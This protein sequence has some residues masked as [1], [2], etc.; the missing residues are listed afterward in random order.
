[1]RLAVLVFLSTKSEKQEKFAEFGEYLSENIISAL[2][3]ETK[4][5]KLFERKR[6]DLILGENSLS[7]SGLI[8]ADQARKIGELVPVDAVLSGT[9]TKLENYIDVNSR[10]I[11]A[12]TGEIMLTYSA[13]VTLTNDLKSLFTDRPVKLTEEDVCKANEN[14]INFLLNDISTPEKVRE[15]VKEAVK[16]PFEGNC[17]A[18]HYKIMNRFSRYEID[19]PEYQ[20]FLMKTIDAIPHPSKDYRAIETLRFIARKSKD[21]KKWELCLRI[22]KK[23]E[24]HSITGALRPFLD[25]PHKTE[26][27]NIIYKRIDQY[28]VLLKNNE[29]GLPKPVTFNKGFHQMLYALDNHYATDNTVSFYCYLKYKNDLTYDKDMNNTVDNYLTRIYINEKNADLKLKML[30]SLCDFY[31][32]RQPDNELADDLFKF[33]S[34]FER[35]SYMKKNPEEEAKVPLAHLKIFIEKCKPMF[36]KTIGFTKYNSQKEDRINFCL[37]NNIKCPGSVPSAE[38]CLKQLSSK[39]W[40]DRV[41]GI[42]LLSKMGADAKIAESAVIKALERNSV[43]NKSQVREIHKHAVIILGNI[44]SSDP[45]ALELLIQNLGSLEY[46]VPQSALKSLVSIGK[47]AVPYLIKGLDSEQGSVQYKC[48]KA[49]GQIGPAA[50]SARPAL[51]KLM[52]SR[53]KDV[54]IIAQESLEEI[55]E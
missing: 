2:S 3:K 20:E 26:D 8:N 14:K 44:R 17:T 55:G 38:D 36:C 42:K 30:N 41:Q 34:K 6:L 39:N 45:K 46:E 13:R 15:I 12:V 25:Y 52:K 18:I 47:P 31:N 48:A 43:E 16:I 11:D 29:I 5:I 7:L 24:A 53:N 33:A 35:T 10:V 51:Q 28:F 50:K 54:A 49:L 9:F 19:N 23:S 27:Q 4:K 40:D 21:E 1:M 32:S 22:V 37:E